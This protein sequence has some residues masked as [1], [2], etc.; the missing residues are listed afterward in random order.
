MS[1]ACKTLVISDLDGTLLNS[2]AELSPRSIAAIRNYV[3]AGHDFSIATARNWAT[4]SHILAE[5]PLK[6]PV[7]LFNGAA[8]YDP[9]RR[10]Y[11]RV[12]EIPRGAYRML[13]EL[14]QSQKFSALFYRLEG[15]EQQNC[16]V[17]LD[18]SYAQDFVEERRVR[19]GKVYTQFSRFSD[20]DPRGLIYFS[21]L[22]EYDRLLPLYEQ[23]KTV[24]GITVSFYRNIYTPGTWFL[25]ICSA[26]TSKK[27]A[28]E[29]IRKKCGY[30][31]ITAFGDN[32][33]DMPLFEAA[34]YT[35]ASG[36]GVEELK[37]LASEVLDTNDRDG[38]AQWLE[39]HM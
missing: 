2:K 10:I 30:T 27:A 15:S 18:T 39:A 21:L 23:M 5:I 7:I 13:T 3:A 6:T 34:D 24:P 29:Y 38:A 14:C 25:E 9:V 36:N 22:E 20:I 1:D 19:Y 35:C 12:C 26:E 33:N 17:Y 32:Y 31:H 28:L 11:S 4:V 16:Y 8:I 37:A